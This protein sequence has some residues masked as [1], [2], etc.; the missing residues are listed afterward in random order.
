MRLER[1]ASNTS[2]VASFILTC[3]SIL[4]SKENKRITVRRFAAGDL[5]S[6]LLFGQWKLPEGCYRPQ[7]GERETPDIHWRRAC[8][9]LLCFSMIYWWHFNGGESCLFYE[10]SVKRTQAQHWTLRSAFK[11]TC[12]WSRWRRFWLVNFSTRMAQCFPSCGCKRC[13]QI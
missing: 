12:S 4:Y 3:T 11:W 7:T 1:V 8:T 6:A 2:E 10:S 13:F 5:E 9:L